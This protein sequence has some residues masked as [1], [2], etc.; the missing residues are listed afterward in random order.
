MVMLHGPIGFHGWIAAQ[1]SVFVNDNLHFVHQASDDLLCGQY[2]GCDTVDH[3][4]AD[5]DGLDVVGG[6]HY[7]YMVQVICGGASSFTVYFV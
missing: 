2:L 5:G 4:S 6:F 3:H 7:V 1:R